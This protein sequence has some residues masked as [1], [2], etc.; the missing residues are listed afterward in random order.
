MG[1]KRLVLLLALF[2]VSVG[3]LLGGSTGALPYN[4][5]DN[6]EDTA[7][8]YSFLTVG[9]V[10]GIEKEDAF[11]EEGKV[12]GAELYIFRLNY[13]TTA[14]KKK[15]E[16]REVIFQVPLV[17]GLEEDEI[18][19]L[20]LVLD[21]N[22]NGKVDPG[23]LTVGGQGKIDLENKQ[24]RFTEPFEHQDAVVYILRADFPHL[25]DGDFLVVKMKGSSIVVGY[26]IENDQKKA[27]SNN[28]MAQSYHI[29]GNPAP[30][31]SW[32]VQWNDGVSS[33]RGR[34]ADVFEFS[35]TYLD[36]N[37]DPPK[38]HQVWID[39]NRNRIYEEEEKF[40]MKPKISYS[41]L[42]YRTGQEFT[43]DLV[44]IPVD[45]EEP[46]NYQ[47][48]FTNTNDKVANGQG[49]QQREIFVAPLVEAYAWVE[50]EE[51]KFVG[52]KEILLNLGFVHYI[53]VELK[54]EDFEKFDF[55]P[56]K[57]E[58]IILNPRQPVVDN[59]NEEYQIIHFLLT[60]PKEEKPGVYEIPSVVVHY[61]ASYIVEGKSITAEGEVL[62]KPLEAG[63]LVEKL[64]VE[65]LLLAFK[66]SY[67][68][69]VINIGDKIS[70]I[71]DVYHEPTREI[72]VGELKEADLKIGLAPFKILSLNTEEK[73]LDGVKL[74]R[75]SF[76][77]SLY[78]FPQEKGESFLLKLPLSQ[79]KIPYQIL[80]AEEG[81]TQ[82]KQFLTLPDLPVVLN[83]LVKSDKA[84]PK[85]PLGAAEI[86]K[87]EFV[88]FIFWAGVGL[89]V[90][91]FFILLV[92]LTKKRIERRKV[93]SSKELL[94]KAEERVEESLVIIRNLIEAGEKVAQAEF[95][96]LFV[97][98]K[99]YLGLQEGIGINEGEARAKTSQELLELL[100][101]AGY[102][103]KT[104][105]A[106]EG[107][108]EMLNK[109]YRKKIAKEEIESLLKR[110]G[111]FFLF[112]FRKK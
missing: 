13:G 79:V 69:E 88:W 75:I 109:V 29:E 33:D 34:S 89:I 9:S 98:F 101:E 72:L 87:P 97:R 35:V 49:A 81:E 48:Y 66:I 42:N 64:E 83:T 52:Q 25:E 4:G 54:E 6:F 11:K 41:D 108:F 36:I 100:K 3:L 110:L 55:S 21:E 50:E 1:V 45:K 82:E 65:K 14:K 39:L 43:A 19:N 92:T 56:F 112:G 63:K 10:S 78:W 22:K 85:G 40:E 99:V 90:L 74:T 111:D 8:D 104:T 2:F 12:L 32:K 105:K 57:V 18:K 86:E 15:L 51:K 31:L 24:I 68:K 53:G 58:K 26:D 84:P 59:P 16:I 7:R 61:T 47:F 80:S 94:I 60:L 95:V 102:E 46:V 27:A 73:D 71:I 37:N 106:V 30:I 91:F 20:E 17:S 38:T 107:I 67:P 28:Y 76:E 44:I 77:F 23:E 70:V 5:I 93:L 103:K 96:D 62:T